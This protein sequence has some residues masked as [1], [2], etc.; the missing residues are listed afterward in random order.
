M[1]KEQTRDVLM[2]HFMNPHNAGELPDANGVGDVGNPLCG[3]II[4]L[5]LRIKEDRIEKA[6]FKSFGCRAAIAT[7]SILTDLVEGKKVEEALRITKDDVAKVLGELPPLKQNCAKLAELALK[8]ALGDYLSRTKSDRT[9]AD[10]V[11]ERVHNPQEWRA[12]AD[13]E[14]DRDAFETTSVPL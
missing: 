11:A 13:L 6:T 8:A 10:Q 2:D 12:N 4:R 1:P 5:F 14:L 3:D 9:L 7:S